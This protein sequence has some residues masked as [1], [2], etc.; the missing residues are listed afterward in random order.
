MTLMQPW[1][2]TISETEDLGHRATTFLVPGD[3]GTRGVAEA[4]KLQEKSSTTAAFHSRP[5]REGARAIGRA[6]LH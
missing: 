4:Q 2:D 5:G 6:A 1:P 3:K